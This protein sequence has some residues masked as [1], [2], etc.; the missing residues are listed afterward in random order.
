MDRHENQH[1]MAEEEELYVVYFSQL[2]KSTVFQTLDFNVNT[3]CDKNGDFLVHLAA[4]K[5]Q[6]YTRRSFTN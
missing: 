5:G 3:E 6:L 2:K 4:R 1:H